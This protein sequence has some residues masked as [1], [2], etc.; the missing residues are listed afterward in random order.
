MSGLLCYPPCKKGYS[1]N[2]PVCW[3]NCPAG[4]ND[5]SAL[6]TDS[7]DDCT[8]SVKNIGIN[9]VALA[10][11]AATAATE[12]QFDMLQII[13]NFIGNLG[14]VPIDLANEFCEKAGF[15]EFEAIV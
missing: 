5:C 12:G 2:G 1:G 14:G 9:V 8:D 15:A 6:C 4:K 11:A 13:E 10:V 3:Q 7:T